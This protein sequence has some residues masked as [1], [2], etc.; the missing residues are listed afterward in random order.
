MVSFNC[1][2]KVNLETGEMADDFPGD[3]CTWHARAHRPLMITEW[4]FPALDAGLPCRHGAGQRVPTQTDRAFA[5]TAFQKLLFI[6]P[7]LVG[8]DFFMWTDDPA[9]GVS[10]VFPEDSNYG[11]VNEKDEP[12]PLL[13]TAASALHPLAY[14]IH[15]G[16]LT[17]LAVSMPHGQCLVSNSGK[18]AGS[19]HVAL[20]AD[21]RRSELADALAP[22]KQQRYAL[23]LRTT[24]GGHFARGVLAPAQP[25]RDCGEGS[26]TAVAFSYLP[27]CKWT[28][29][30]A[31]R[32]PLVVADPTEAPLEQVVAA[33]DAA[34][35]WRN[36]VPGDPRQLA[37]RDAD[38]VPVPCQVDDLGGGQELALQVG[39]LAPA[40]SRTIFL[41]SASRGAARCL[42][43]GATAA[44]GSGD[45]P[46]TT[47]C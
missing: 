7:F 11:L 40:A 28:T 33:L 23:A 32:V 44:A 4:S 25:L 2:R 39:T 34:K 16:L 42:A 20:T 27:G 13:T 22:G 24:P 37:A 26:R 19:Y 8:S 10:A 36:G 43:R 45:L 15:S 31:T 47:A 9:P 17:N 3:L 29:S 14:D 30:A 46:C 6:T 35:I 41:L 21:G 18:V 38:G 12:F 1:Y 5:F